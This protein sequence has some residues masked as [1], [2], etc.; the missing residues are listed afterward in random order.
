MGVAVLA[1]HDHPHPSSPKSFGFGGCSRRPEGVVVHFL[2]HCYTSGELYNLLRHQAIA[3]TRPKR[4]RVNTSSGR[5]KHNSG[6]KSKSWNENSS[7]S[8]CSTA[9][10]RIL[11][12]HSKAFAKAMHYAAISS[13]VVAHG[14]LL[15]PSWELTLTRRQPLLLSGREK[16]LL[17]WIGICP[18]LLLVPGLI[19][20]ILAY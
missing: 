8:G 9:S 18:I 14:L 6:C 2:A 7:P 15:A 17:H 19:P 13:V 20:E 3:N 10:Y 11:L 16:S 12:V 5:L 1:S 4:C